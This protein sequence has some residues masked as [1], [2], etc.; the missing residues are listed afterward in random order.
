MAGRKS[1][2]QDI[3]KENSNDALRKASSDSFYYQLLTFD[4]EPDPIRYTR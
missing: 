3:Q 4:F 2:M 1:G